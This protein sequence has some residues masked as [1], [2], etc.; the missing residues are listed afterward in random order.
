MCCLLIYS[1]RQA[2]G[3]T[4][5]GHTGFLT[6]LPSAVLALNFLARGGFS[7]SFSCLPAVES[8]YV[9]ERIN[10]SPLLGHIYKSI[11]FF[12]TPGFEL[13]SQLQKV[14]RLPTEPPG[15]PACV[16]KT[17][18]WGLLVHATKLCLF[19]RAYDKYGN[20]NYAH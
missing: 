8:S 13:A 12:S 18:R 6:H 17:F 7:R 5:R 15:R 9:Y 2:C 3:R 20:R 19:T 4:S 10:R 16:I 1:G 11:Y 14:S